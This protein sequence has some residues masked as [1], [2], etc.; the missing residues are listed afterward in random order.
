MTVT[1]HQLRRRIDALRTESD[2]IEEIDRLTLTRLEAG[3]TTYP[4]E[5]S[6]YAA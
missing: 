6:R 5:E 3:H 2:L 1:I 4:E